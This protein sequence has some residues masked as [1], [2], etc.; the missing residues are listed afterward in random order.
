MDISTLEYGS[1]EEMIKG[2][3]IMVRDGW[4]VQS[5]CYL[6]TDKYKVEFIRE[7]LH[8]ETSISELEATSS[9]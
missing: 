7:S 6:V 5:I 1:R 9:A 2:I 3:E 8:S 4:V